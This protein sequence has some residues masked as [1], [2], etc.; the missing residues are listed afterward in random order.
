MM[1]KITII[2][3][4]VAMAAGMASAAGRWRGDLNGDDRVD[5]ADMVYLANAIKS[6]SSDKDCDLNTSGRVDDH[7]LDALANIILSGQLTEN[8]G[9]NVGIG[10]WDDSGEDFGGTVGAPARRTTRSAESTRFYIGN[11]K[12]T[13]GKC[14]IDFGIEEGDVAATG[15]LFNIRLPRELSFDENNIVS[16]N[17]SVF[18]GHRLY[19][20]ARILQPDEW[21]DKILRFIVFSKDLNPLKIT[22]G[23]LGQ[24]HYGCS[25]DDTM[26]Y[27]FEECQVI[28]SGSNNVI[29]PESSGNWIHWKPIEVSSIWLDTGD[30]EMRKGEEFWL[31]ANIEPWDATNRNI[32]WSVSDSSVLSVE[33]NGESSV[34]VRALKAGS[35]NVTVTASN[36]LT[37]TCQIRVIQ[38]PERITLDKSEL[39]LTLGGDPGLSV[40]KLTAN[41]L[42]EDASDKT[43][44]WQSQDEWVASV[45]A[46]GNVTANHAGTVEIFASTNYGHSVSCHVTVIQLAT[47]LAIEPSEVSLHI[48]ETTYLNANI[49]PDD[50]SERTLEWRSS[51]TAVATVDA[52]GLVKALAIGETTITA[53]AADGSGMKATAVVRVHPIQAESVSISG[54]PSGDIH[55]GDNF[56]L[57]A[58]VLPENTTNK[59]VTWT[60]SDASI[61]S[62]DADGTVRALAEG[63]AVITATTADGSGKSAQMTVKVLPNLADRIVIDPSE[64]DIKIGETIQLKATIYPDN[65]TSKKVNWSSSNT[66]VAT[67]DANGLVK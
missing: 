55:I 30:R 67:V 57:T 59:S 36:G 18:S 66:A 38:D 6:G 35:A 33:Q 14:S 53:A 22:K 25:N 48:G 32:T 28:A 31:N 65:A 62:V 52:N 61:A 16:L 37:A 47:G 21:G 19:G 56:K 27:T 41:V 24:L 58:T 15:F 29:T 44:N 43:V 60:S 12:M 10:G 23:V 17:E 39:R 34:I 45:D 54:I 26:G 3:M 13:D 51:N 49:S 5:M 63:S 8:S 46:D 50:V 7:D 11:P 1:K 42:P 2:L 9:L 64:S 4:L 20:K 40:G